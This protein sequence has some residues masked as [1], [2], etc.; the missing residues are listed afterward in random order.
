V[1]RDAFLN[2]GNVEQI[3]WDE[4]RERG[5]AAYTGLGTA[6]R[7]IGNA[8]DIEVGEPLVPLPGTRQKRP[9]PTLTRRILH[10][11]IGISADEHLPTHKDFP[12]SGGTIR[13]ATAAMRAGDL[14][15][16]MTR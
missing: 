9:Y 16:S 13:R 8:C 6:M 2:T 7:S 10:R 3:G 14:H 4:V 11:L 12:T 1:A 5:F 15:R